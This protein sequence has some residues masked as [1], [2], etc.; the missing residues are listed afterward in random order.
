M[1]YQL[2]LSEDQKK[3][4]SDLIR[5]DLSTHRQYRLYLEEH[6]NEMVVD[7]SSSVKETE[8]DIS[9][10]NGLLELLKILQEGK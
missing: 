6:G 8:A 9:R 5:C 1:T 2:P 3:Y 7:L 4:L 10:A